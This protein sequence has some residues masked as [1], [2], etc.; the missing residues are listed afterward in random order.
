MF[1]NLFMYNN[2]NWV[3]DKKWIRILL[4]K[5][6]AAHGHSL[7]GKPLWF[8]TKC[9]VSKNENENKDLLT[10]THDKCVE[11]TRVRT[12]WLSPMHLGHNRP[13]VLNVYSSQQKKI[14]LCHP[15]MVTF[16]NMWIPNCYFE[17]QK[18]KYFHYIKQREKQKITVVWDVP[19]CDT[20]D[21]QQSQRN[22]LLPPLW[23]KSK[24]HGKDRQ[25]K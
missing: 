17:V 9:F 6:N 21:K 23:Q 1:I 15:T 19:L 7:Y 22:L 14:Q 5:C 12:H 3:L 2:N 8:P 24:L 10:K 13:F 4:K 11:K 20:V 18:L 16:V 25:K